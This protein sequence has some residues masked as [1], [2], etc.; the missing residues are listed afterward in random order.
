MT[1]RYGKWFLVGWI[2]FVAGGC[3][4]R[5]SEAENARPVVIINGLEL[6]AE[7]LQREVG[8]ASSRVSPPGKTAGTE[9]EWLG[10]LIERELMVQEA[11]R[12]GLDRNKEFMSTI[13]RFWKEALLKQLI[14]RKGQEVAATVRVYEPELEAEYRR[15]QEEGKVREGVSLGQ[16]REEILHNVRER[17]Q[18]QA[19]EEW[20]ASLRTKAK[21]HVDL[22]GIEELR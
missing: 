5:S 7:E 11:Q 1:H 10:R 3:A 19:M 17:K 12:L 8:T 9:P 6:T 2:C 14:R 22:K 16:M 21:I 20:V 15:L 13:E 18:A 4:P